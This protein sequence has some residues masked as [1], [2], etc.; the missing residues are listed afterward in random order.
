MPPE[1]KL[2]IFEHLAGRVSSVCLGLTCRELYKIHWKIHRKIPLWAMDRYSVTW[3]EWEAIWGS[4]CSWFVGDISSRLDK[5]FLWQFI[6]AWGGGG[7]DLKIHLPC[8]GQLH[9]VDTRFVTES[10]WM[11]RLP[12]RDHRHVGG[13]S[14]GHF[15]VGGD[16]VVASVW[17]REEDEQ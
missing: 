10:Q 11:K 5:T 1:I 17:E 6:D 16:A 8:L 7:K 9:K 12:C 15:L 2:M 3:R 13:R 4:L 14:Y